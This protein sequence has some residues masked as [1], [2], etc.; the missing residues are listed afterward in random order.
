MNDL[1]DRDLTRLFDRHD[2]ADFEP[3]VPFRDAI[4]QAAPG[5]APRRLRAVLAAVALLATIAVGLV[6]VLSRRPERA[7]TPTPAVTTPV[8]ADIP[9]AFERDGAA[10]WGASGRLDQAQWIGAGTRPSISPDG[11]YV[12]AYRPA[13]G[14]TSEAWL[15][16]PSRR[17]G[18]SIGTVPLDQYTS[19]PAAWA[20]N[21]PVAALPVPGGIAIV[22]PRRPPTA[23]EATVAL[24]DVDTKKISLVVSPD[25]AQV[26]VRVG[27]QSA[28]AT[29]WLLADVATGSVRPVPIAAALQTPIWT[30]TGLYTA[31]RRSILRLTLAPSATE[32][33]EAPGGSNAD[34][35]L[36]GVSADGHRIAYTL[37]C[38]HGCSKVRVLDTT[39]GTSFEV[40][41]GTATGISAD[42][43]HLMVVDACDSGAVLVSNPV[44]VV[45][46]APGAIPVGEVTPTGA[47]QATFCRTSWPTPTTTG[48]PPPVVEP[49]VND[50]AVVRHRDG[51][52][53]RVDLAT[54]E[55]T[56]L[57]YP[58]VAAAQPQPPTIVH[59]GHRFAWLGAGGGAWSVDD[60]LNAP[61]EPIPSNGLRVHVI[62]DATPGTIW[63]FQ[64]ARRDEYISHAARV[65]VDT[66]DRVGFGGELRPK[67]PSRFVGTAEDG[68]VVRQVAD[69]D[70]RWLAGTG[71]RRALTLPAN[72]QIA[73]G[74]VISCDQ[75]C[76]TLTT[77]AVGSATRHVIAL[78]DT[79]G[80]V[81]WFVS[82]DRSQ[83]AAL[84]PAVRGGLRFLVVDLNR[85]A[86]R[87]LTPIVTGPAATALVLTW[88]ADSRRLL[89]VDGDE[90]LWDVDAADARA[91]RLV[92]TIP[93][94]RGGP[95]IQDEII[96][97]AAS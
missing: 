62:A 60:R 65:Q 86:A 64:L 54:G 82:P 70:V 71:N 87:L 83:L 29:A 19:S 58:P 53:T 20:Q 56:L 79:H 67:P 43:S 68:I 59:S 25:G 91:P 74:L 77:Q 1:G 88:A 66:G 27:E 96:E 3:R 28:D 35:F 18:A 17:S 52:L 92:T 49:V 69:G 6:V 13:A 36:G 21:S 32:V 94:A 72:A 12:I 41:G 89:T 38:V 84:I 33:L 15:Y 39:K 26:L 50:I 34:V 16:Q 63:L 8:P 78:P 11:R 46:A 76:R 55:T 14:K 22:D 4:G 95:G 90:R 93:L 73:N 10:W 61:A 9:I 51:R 48:A 75:A 40:G 5:R 44:R 80:A 57:D 30:T 2:D 42:G 47:S 7:P 24:P 23:L 85:D 45:S 31:D 81:K 37:G 97:I